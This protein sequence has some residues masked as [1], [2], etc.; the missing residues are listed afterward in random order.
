MAILLA[1]GLFSY[2]RSMSK[3][4]QLLFCIQAMIKAC[5]ELKYTV[6]FRL[7]WPHQQTFCA[8]HNKIW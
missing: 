5:T 8:S 6:L 7:V 2:F 3:G 1:T 4:F